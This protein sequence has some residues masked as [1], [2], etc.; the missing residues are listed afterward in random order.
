[1]R[2]FFSRRSI[3]VAIIL[4]ALGIGIFAFAYKQGLKAPVEPPGPAVAQPERTVIGK[5]VE[6]RE[7]EAFTYG[8][9]AAHLLFVGG[10][11]GGYE[12]NSVILAYRFIDYLE[13]N[14]NAIPEQITVTV[15]P[16]ANPDGAYR[17]IQKEGRFTVSDVPIAE[18]APGTG[19][20]NARGVDLN[21]NFDCKW[22]PKSTWRNVIVSAG[23]K[24]FSEPETVAIRDFVLERTP[25]GV[26]F[27]HSQANA[28]YASQCEYGILPKTLDMVNAY[29]RSA[30][31]GAFTSFDQYEISGDADGWL[32]SINIPAIS[33]EL[34]THQ[35]IEW[36]QNLEGINALFRY[37]SSGPK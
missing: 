27:W 21:R 1:M 25:D 31:Y 28:V 5:S 14:P 22:K 30:G 17:V 23:T 29:A 8:N 4:V 34:K 24:A 32:A 19:R 20:F 9:G 35:T 15:I 18:Q 10:I 12:W 36:E 11:H 13:A 33:V 16:S 37:F 26:I 6:G 3:A 7:I 2:V